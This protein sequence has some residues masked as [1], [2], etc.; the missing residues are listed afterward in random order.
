MALVVISIALG[1][2]TLVATRC[3]DDSLHQ[4]A[5]G[6]VNPFAT[7]A[8][9]LVVNGQTGV[10]ADLA[11]RLKEAQLPGLGD[12]QPLVMGRAV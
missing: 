7:L 12:V 6:A 10:P 11:D 3:L 8:D 2:G 1:V 4:A 5:Q 9:L